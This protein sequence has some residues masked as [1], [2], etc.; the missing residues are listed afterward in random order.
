MRPSSI[1]TCVAVL[2][3]CSVA[4]LV[5]TSGV[6]IDGGGPQPAIE[7]TT[8]DVIQD[9]SFEAGSPNPYWSESPAGYVIRGDGCTEHSGVFHAQMNDGPRSVSQ[10]VSIP[11][12]G[13]A[14]GT[15]RVLATVYGRAFQLDIPSGSSH[16]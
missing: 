10:T 6:A 3:V 4:S 1:W 14:T 2:F 9:G 13:S 11:N 15:A 7:Q 12:A 5:P 16:N 8:I